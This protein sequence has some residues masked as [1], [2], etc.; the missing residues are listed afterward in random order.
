M[1]IDF[2]QLR[3]FRYADPAEWRSDDV[4]YAAKIT[5]IDHDDDA[6]P[7]LT[8]DDGYRIQVDYDWYEER[9]PR[10]GWY[11]VVLPGGKPVVH[12]PNWFEGSPCHRV[13][14]AYVAAEPAN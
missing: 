5:D 7:T 6:G 11:F 10:A 12:H 3:Q 13:V 1:Q 14:P 2:S 4:T 9:E 8:L